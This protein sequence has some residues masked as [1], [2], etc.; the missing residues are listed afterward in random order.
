ML[1]SS[2]LAAARQAVDASI[3]CLEQARA[4]RT[5]HPHLFRQALWHVGDDEVM[6]DTRDHLHCQL[7]AG[8][9]PLSPNPSSSGSPSPDL[10]DILARFDDMPMGDV[11]QEPFVQDG[12]D[13]DGFYE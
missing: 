8:G 2:A 5:L 1:A 12:G 13:D 11:H 3:E 6:V 10:I 7:Q 9:R 4:Y